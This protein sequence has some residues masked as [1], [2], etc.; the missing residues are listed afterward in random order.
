MRNVL[1]CRPGRGGSSRL[2]GVH[3]RVDSSSSSCLTERPCS[4]FPRVRDTL[5]VALELGRKGIGYEIDLDLK[6]VIRKKPGLDYNRWTGE[7][8]LLEEKTGAKNLRK[9]LQTKVHR[10]KSV[11][12]RRAKQ[13][14]DPT[15]YWHNRIGTTV[16]FSRL[17][18]NRTRAQGQ[19]CL[20]SEATGANDY[21]P[22][23][24]EWSTN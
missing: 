22:S 19:R 3:F 12:S 10:Q 4:T 7:D 1:P 13:P 18:N 20:V 15:E 8:Y 9:T 24:R 6:H 21:M 17:R 23:S 16:S 14:L 11:A 2:S 5:K